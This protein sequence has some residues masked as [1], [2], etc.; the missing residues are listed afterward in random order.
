MQ[1]FVL[2]YNK[3]EQR[4]KDSS[5]F[6]PTKWEESSTAMRGAVKELI[7]AVRR[8]LMIPPP[9]CG[10]AALTRLLGAPS[11]GYETDLGLPSGVVPARGQTIPMRIQ[12]LALPKSQI[13]GV[14]VVLLSPRVA[15]VFTDPT[16]SM[17][18]P[19][20]EARELLGKVKRYQD[21]VLRVTENLLELLLLLYLGG[22]LATTSLCKETVNFFAV[23]KSAVRLGFL[24]ESGKPPSG[25]KKGASRSSTQEEASSSGDQASRKEKKE[26]EGEKAFRR[27]DLPDGSI[28]DEFGWVWELIQRLIMGERAG[29][30]W[31]RTPPRTTLTS[32]EVISEIDCEPESLE[33]GHVH[34][35]QADL[36][37]WYYH[38]LLEI[39]QYPYFVIG[40]ISLIMFNSF[41]K[42]RRYPEMV[43]GAGDIFVCLRVL[44]MGWSWSV[45]T[46]QTAAEDVCSCNS[47]MFRKSMRVR[48]GS[49]APRL[50]SLEKIILAVHIDDLI[51]W[52]W[53]RTPEEAR[54]GALAVMKEFTR[55]FGRFGLL[56]H[57][58][59]DG[60]HLEIVGLENGKM[61]DGRHRTRAKV[62]SLQTTDEGTKQ[63]LRDSDRGGV[64]V[65]AVQKVVGHWAFQMLP[66]RASF[67]VFGQVY[68]WLEH[69]KHRPVATLWE[70][71]KGELWCIVFLAPLLHMENDLPLYPWVYAVDAS[72]K[73]FGVCVCRPLRGAVLEALQYAEQKGWFVQCAMD[74]VEGESESSSSPRSLV[75]GEDSEE[76]GE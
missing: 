24:E 33:D 22:M 17:L 55:V 62:K 38:L 57:K 46:A 64:E 48:F 36:P 41:L 60:L 65:K 75:E 54:E 66:N 3:A 69:H 53:G 58:E 4:K 39:W 35:G 47:G 32:P 67:A 13:K 50:N 8:Y 2:E 72:T 49:P 19:E 61:G 16:R 76:E 5:I 34:M 44:L 28:L 68:T 11:G 26:E 70:G 71:V 51:T 59:H 21:P 45:W 7:D 56:L 30:C 27:K 37:L 31:W 20:S 14:R 74:T 15:R 73:G 1:G 43:G 63:L 52:V 18:R 29:N 42:S 10:R 9:L 12:A 40:G 6:F 23:V 25:K